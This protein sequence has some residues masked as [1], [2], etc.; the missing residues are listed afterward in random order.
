MVL[1][2][3]AEGVVASAQEP[4]ENE[5]PAV[6][7]LRKRKVLEEMVAR[8]RERQAA[9]SKEQ[10]IETMKERLK[11]EKNLRE[12]WARE[13]KT[14]EQALEF[15]GKER[16]PQEAIQEEVLVLN[17]PLCVLQVRPYHQQ[18]HAGERFATEVTL[19][20]ESTCP[21]DRVDVRLGYSQAQVRP[22]QVFDF[23]LE[24]Y[25]DPESPAEL[26]FE[27]SSISYS[28]ELANPV[29]ASGHTPVLYI[30]WEAIGEANYPASITLGRLGTKRSMNSA[31]YMEDQNLL[32][33]S[34]IIG[35][36]FV[37]ADVQ[38]M[39]SA[40]RRG[41]GLLPLQ[42]LAR[43]GPAKSRFRPVSLSLQGPVETVVPGEV[44]E[45]EVRLENPDRLPFEEVNLFMK[46]DPRKVEVLDW[47]ELGWIRRDINVYDGHAHLRFPFNV[48]TRNSVSNRLGRVHY[49]MGTTQSHPMPSGSLVKIRC[50]A[51]AVGAA[52]SFNLYAKA[53]DERQETDI[54]MGGKSV[55][56]RS[57]S[58]SIAESLSR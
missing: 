1:G 34:M 6:R 37:N 38:V 26:S 41:H 40:R 3:L 45:M 9:M 25:L 21:F 22:L 15:F 23:P 31:I 53:A 44:F 13:G 52:Q 56:Q 7:T 30:V 28:A 2:L 8:E 17:R 32:L 50:Q 48:H 10:R 35:S 57:E 29:R 42:D 12:K 20:S 55:I 16:P 11:N 5:S 4:V 46:F 33:A 18:V 47:D 51:K 27:E 36:S 43:E 24:G 58:A 14:P 39:P 54:R 49:R 19:Y